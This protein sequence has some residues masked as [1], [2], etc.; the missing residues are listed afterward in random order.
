M[1]G[2][3]GCG[4]MVANVG[5]CWQKGDGSSSAWPEAR[6]A[7][8][9]SAPPQGRRRSMGAKKA[10]VGGSP[11]GNSPGR[12]MGVAGAGLV[13]QP[14]RRCIEMRVFLIEGWALFSAFCGLLLNQTPM[15]P[16]RP[17]PPLSWSKSS[18]ASNCVAAC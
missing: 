4:R 7:H 2:R 5:E 8:E 16:G 12:L 6:H 11:M 13:A 9:M 17:V 15:I 1:D 10:R 3:D 14:G 18:E